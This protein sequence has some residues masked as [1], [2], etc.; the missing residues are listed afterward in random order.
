MPI[1][2]NTANSIVKSKANSWN[3][4]D[5]V[6]ISNDFKKLKT[7]TAT[8]FAS[9]VKLRQTSITVTAK[10]MRKRV[11]IEMPAFERASMIFFG[12]ARKS[13]SMNIKKSNRMTASQPADP[14]SPAM[15]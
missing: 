3:S 2:N 13:L 6:A 14:A 11:E 10:N 5:V 1:P 9:P 12:L 8:N 4:A 7:S 15:F